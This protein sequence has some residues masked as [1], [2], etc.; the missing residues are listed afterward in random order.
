MTSPPRSSATRMEPTRDAPG[1]PRL[2]HPALGEADQGRLVSL[3]RCIM[4]PPSRTLVII[5]PIFLRDG[6][7]VDDAGHLAAAEDED[8]SQ[9]SSSTSRSSPT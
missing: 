5:R 6:P 8:R 7:A 9:S 1:F 3:S 4:L 2:H